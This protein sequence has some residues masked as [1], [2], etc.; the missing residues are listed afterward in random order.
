MQGCG[1][2]EVTLSVYGGSCMALA[3]AL[4]FQPVSTFLGSYGL[5]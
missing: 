1:P 4:L 5:M 3:P 2:G